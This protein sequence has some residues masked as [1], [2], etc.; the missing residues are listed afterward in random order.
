MPYK[1]LYNIRPCP[2]KIALTWSLLLHVHFHDQPLGY[3][4]AVKLRRNHNHQTIMC[5]TSQLIKTK[6][7]FT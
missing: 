7:W 1:I 4:N 6:M 2:D 3:T 5:W